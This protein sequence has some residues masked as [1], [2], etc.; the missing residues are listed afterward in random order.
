MEEDKGLIF[1]DPFV[2]IVVDDMK[3]LV[4]KL[5]SRV[6]SL[7]GG[8]PKPA[9]SGTTAQAAKPVANGKDDDDD[10]IDLFGSDSEV[11]GQR[12]FCHLYLVKQHY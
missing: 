3:A 2:L 11:S 1:K 6:S 5:E 12:W 7:E 8:S 4:M 9:E 10:D